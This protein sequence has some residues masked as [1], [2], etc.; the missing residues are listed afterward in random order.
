MVPMPDM[1]AKPQHAVLE[2]YFQ[3]YPDTPREVILKSD[4]L[5][6]GQ[7]FT[8]AALLAAS[9]SLIKSYRLFSYDLVPMK[10][11][12][13]KESIRVPEHLILLG[14]QFDLRPVLV[15]TSLAPDSPYV[16]DVIN[17]RLVLCNDG[18]VLCEVRF[19]IAPPYYAQKT[20]DGTRFHEIIANG[21]F[22]TIFRYC[23][24]WG[25][26]EECGFCDINANARQMKHSHDFTLTAPIKSLDH[27]LE[28]AHAV[29]NDA[30]ILWGQPVPLSFLL[31]GGTIKEELHGK[32]ED[33]FYGEYVEALKWDGAQR[34]INLQTNAKPKEVLRRYRTLGLDSHHADMEVWDRRLFEWICPG[35]THRVGWDNWVRWLI[36]SVDV[37]GE[38]AVKPLFVAGIEMARPHGFTSVTEAVASTTAGME[39]LMSHGVIVR[40]NQWR[41]APN[42]FLV[43]EYMQPA[44]PLDYYIQL[45]SNRYEI[46]KKY[47]LPLPNQ[48]QLLPVMHY[49]GVSH[50]AHE[51]YIHLMENTYPP[52]IIDIINRYS[53][54][55]ESLPSN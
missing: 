1:S 5:R 51:D 41:R 23:Q 24:F 8:D 30:Y 10:E 34:F 11:L 2:E 31:S 4:L 49:L 26:E 14:G 13:R 17:D 45:F 29:T 12:G 36:D 42:T 43:R 33:E 6:Y 32:N 7:W 53:V 25:R 3:R 37:F 28:V 35:K 21:F 38:G 48:N 20:A 19:H 16:I 47:R 27:I 54:P 9:G 50:A 15:Q 52:N 40:F 55:W 22:I 46:W 39:Y 44:V 18:Q